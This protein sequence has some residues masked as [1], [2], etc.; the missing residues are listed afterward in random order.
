MTFQRAGEVEFQKALGGTNGLTMGEHTITI[1]NV[2]DDTTKP[3]LDIDAFMIEVPLSASTTAAD[4]VSSLIAPVGI[5]DAN[6]SSASTRHSI[7]YDN[8]WTTV[9]GQQEFILGTA[10]QTNVNGASV[11]FTFEGEGFNVLGA[12]GPSQGSYRVEVDGQQAGDLNAN[13]AVSVPS[14]NLVRARPDFEMSID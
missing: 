11:T 14:S 6:L 8:T 12:V 9:T 7:T 5:D 3:V 13:G 1:T 10:H 4:S 2:G